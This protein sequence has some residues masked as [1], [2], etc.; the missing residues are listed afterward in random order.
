[1]ILSKRVYSILE[2]YGGPVVHNTTETSHKATK[3]PQHNT[4][5]TTQWK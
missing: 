4:N 3:S 5:S 2:V 1:M